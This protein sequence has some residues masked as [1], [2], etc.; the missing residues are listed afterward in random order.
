MIVSKSR[1]IA[2]LTDLST[3]S[4]NV[5]TTDLHKLTIQAAPLN[6][7]QTRDSMG[8]DHSNGALSLDGKLDNNFAISAAGL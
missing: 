3:G 6:A 8:L 5:I 4:C 7:Q 2:G 1:G